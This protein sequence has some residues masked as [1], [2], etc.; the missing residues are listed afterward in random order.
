MILSTGFRT[1]VLVGWLNAPATSERPG[2]R[3]DLTRRSDLAH[4]TC[5]CETWGHCVPCQ[6]QREAEW[7]RTLGRGSSV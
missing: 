7:A 2:A 3:P 5:T 6:P 4:P 1:G